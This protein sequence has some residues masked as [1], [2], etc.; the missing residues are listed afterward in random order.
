M[1]LR[2]AGYT[3]SKSSRPEFTSQGIEYIWGL[4][5][6]AGAWFHLWPAPG[7]DTAVIHAAA[8]ELYASRDVVGAVTWDWLPTD[9]EVSRIEDSD[10]HK[11]W[12]KLK[13][14]VASGFNKPENREKFLAYPPDMQR[15][16]AY[17]LIEQGVITYVI[18][19]R[20]A[21]AV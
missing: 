12:E 2:R 16:I 1:A 7:T 3:Y 9:Q 5:G 20:E 19:S 6:S 10:E 15:A 8:R 14:L 13:A 4:A 21:F 17:G 18:R 11:E